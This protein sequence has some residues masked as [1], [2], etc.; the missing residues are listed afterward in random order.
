M[1]VLELIGRVP[2]GILSRS[3]IPHDLETVTHRGAEASPRAVR[4]SRTVVEGVWQGAEALYRSGTQPGLQ[5]CIRVRGEVVLN[6]SLGHARG[7][8]PNDPADAPRLPMTPQTPVNLFSAA[9]AVTAMLVHKLEERGR[10]QLDDPLCEYIPEFTGHGKQAITLRHVLAHRAGIPDLPGDALSLDLLAHPDQMIA[11]LCES[12]PRS[13]AG[14]SPAYHAVSGGFLLAEVIQRVTGDSIR[15]LAEEA[16]RKPLGLRWLH[17]GVE[18][19]DV[20]RVAVNARTGPPAPPPLSWLLARA[21]GAEFSQIVELSNDPRF[22]TGIIPSAN[23]ITTAEDVAR[24]YQCLLD[25]GRFGDTQVFE[26]RTVERART[27][28]GPWGFDRNLVAPIRYSPGF[29]LGSETLSLY[30]WN[31]PRAFGHLGLSNVFCWADPDRALVVA[32]L[33]TG[34]PV[35]STH[36]VRLCQLIGAIHEAFPPLPPRRTPREE[37]RT[38][39]TR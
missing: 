1:D 19:A 17:Y 25:G 36:V 8:G 30:G 24:F 38:P 20:G 18:P 31:H 22:L 23:L 3:R 16:L 27:E 14:S 10:L 21:L 9:K 29:M 35:V 11:R 12:R 5:L 6:R 26:A 4:S 28:Q 37:T 13:S 2:L 32:L 15:K 39:R 7:N 34:K 33:T